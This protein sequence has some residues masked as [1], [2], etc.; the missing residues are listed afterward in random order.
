M[1][2][3]ESDRSGYAGNGSVNCH[4]EV[5]GTDEDPRSPELSLPRNDGRAKPSTSASPIHR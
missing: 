2:A 1:R 3:R 4:Y 5:F